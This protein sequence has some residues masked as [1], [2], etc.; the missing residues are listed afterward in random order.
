MGSSSPS[1]K[2]SSARPARRVHLKAV[3][4]D[5]RKHS[6]L[7]PQSAA[8]PRRPGPRFAAPPGA[9]RPLRETAAALRGGG[10]GPRH[11]PAPSR[12]RAGT[13]PAP[14]ERRSAGLR[15]FG[16]SSLLGIYGFGPPAVPSEVRCGER[17][18]FVRL[19]GGRD[20]RSNEDR[21]RSLQPKIHDD[22]VL[23]FLLRGQ[24]LEGQS[25][26]E[27]CQP[28]CTVLVINQGGGPGALNS[29]PCNQRGLRLL[30]THSRVFQN[31]VSLYPVRLHENR[32]D[33]ASHD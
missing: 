25:R 2:A 14:S 33:Q 12:S 5:P 21:C 29:K 11:S 17:R 31:R 3:R 28:H 27:F 15:V 8:A 4:E 19:L 20:P 9:P 10:G 7:F 23:A 6:L 22:S 24:V 26:T 30:A 1:L 18:F 16:A 32:L 13:S